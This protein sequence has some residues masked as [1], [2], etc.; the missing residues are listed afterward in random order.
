LIILSRPATELSVALMNRAGL[1]PETDGLLFYPRGRDALLAGLRALGILPGSALVI[2]AYICFST[3]AP[4]E[5]A[6]Y[7]IV[8][9]D[10]EPDLRL[11]PAKVLAAVEASDA[12]AVLAVHYFGF[13]AGIERLVNLL[14]PRGVR[15]IED[16]CHSF[17]TH[18]DGER[19]G[20]RGDAAIFSMRK[21][22]PV[23]DGGALRINAGDFDRESL[24]ASP[25]APPAVGRY[26]LTRAVEAVVATI[27]WP[28]IYSSAIDDLKS[29][30][31]GEKN[32]DAPTDV[33]ARAADEGQLQAPSA[34]L[35]R[36]LASEHYLRAIIER[37]AANYARLV[38]AGSALGLHAYIAHLPS[39]CV[40]QW[41]PFADPSGRIVEALRERGVGAC[42]WPWQELPAEVAAQ[43]SLYPVSNDLNRRLVLLPV[44]QSI[45]DRGMRRMLH[46]LKVIRKPV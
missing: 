28:N 18:A 5:Q 12:K 26:L 34:L 29:R 22:L 2:P 8:F 6:G 17:L 43:P 21:T 45:G 38:E 41:A 35:R 14:R 32:D 27:G 39:G 13:S 36:Y 9:V 1:T 23:P 46:V 44:H 24:R 4:L 40:P 3:V 25:A 11:D 15:V 7:R 10:I 37:T 33:A 42:R 16:C 31:R 30:A 20:F 19:A